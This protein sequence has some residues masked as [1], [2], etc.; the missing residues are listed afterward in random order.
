MPAAAV[1]C[2]LEAR[3]VC[4]GLARI[5]SDA[6]ADVPGAVAV[7][8]RDDDDGG[9]AAVN[10]DGG[11]DGVRFRVVSLTLLPPV[12]VASELPPTVADAAAD[13]VRCAFDESDVVDN[14]D[15]GRLLAAALERDD[16]G[17]K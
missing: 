12:L 17:R 7:A 6:A 9:G 3:L 5:A 14:D 13:T 2:R 4:A 16:A 15:D 10:D 8:G 1:P 11:R